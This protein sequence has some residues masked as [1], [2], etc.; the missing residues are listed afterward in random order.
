MKIGTTTFRGEVPRLSPRLLPENAAQD[1]TN[2]R[3]L[4]GDLTSW[5]QFAQTVALENI[6]GVRTIFRIDGN[7]WLAFDEQVDIARAVF[8]GGLDHRVLLTCPA[9]FTT[10]RYTDVTMATSGPQP[11]P[12]ETLPLGVPAPDEIAT[13]SLGVDNTPTTFS[14]DVTDPGDQLAES[15]ISSPTV[16]FSD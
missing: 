16:P 9:L 14:I 11:Y 10:P 6:T 5:R 13:L 3:L 1:A 2:A 4:S 7:V 15:W 8:S 12:A